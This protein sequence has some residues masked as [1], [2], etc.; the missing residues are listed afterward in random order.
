MS[1]LYGKEINLLQGKIKIGN[2]TET[3]TGNGSIADFTE[4]IRSFFAQLLKDEGVVTDASYDLTTQQITLIWTTGQVTTIDVSDFLNTTEIQEQIINQLNAVV[5]NTVGTD[6]LAL[7]IKQEQGKITEISGSIKANT[8]D[9]YGSASTAESKAKKH[10]DDKIAQEV[11]DRDAAIKV[12]T[13]ARI[14]AIKA[15]DATKNQAAGADGLA[16]HIKEENGVITELSGSIATNTYDAYGAAK[17]VQGETDKTV[18]EAY[19]LA[20]AAQTEKEVSDAINVKIQE[21]DLPN[22]YESKGAA[23]ALKNSLKCENN[24]GIVR[25]YWKGE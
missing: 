2:Q 16:L 9:A 23:E 18:K 13:D 24:N 21:L 11:I 15:L 17:A 3:I 20:D 8:Y 12:E 10:A 22:T 19:E 25:L 14:D 6:G 4:T 5:S 7:S 1:N